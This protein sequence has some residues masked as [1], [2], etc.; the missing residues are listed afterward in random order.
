M[1]DPSLEL[2]QAMVAVLK[3]PGALPAAVGGRV[4][5][6]VPLTA[7]YPYIS[8]GDIQVLP[9]KAE[10][11][12]GTEVFPQV[13]IWSRGPGYPEAKAIAKAVLLA[14][15]DQGIQVE[16]F[17]TVVFEVQSINYLRDPDGKTRH[18]AI[19]FRGLLTPS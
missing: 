11:I 1:S 17:N 6:D 3:T 10:C 14:L 5:D 16:G 15:D 2:Q 8:L 12:D 13:D 7:A 19:T 18:A 4:Y 9:D